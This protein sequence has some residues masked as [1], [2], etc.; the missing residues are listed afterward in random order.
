LSRSFGHTPPPPGHIREGG[1][2]TATPAAYRR[3]LTS[4]SHAKNGLQPHDAK[5]VLWINQGKEKG[6]E[7]PPLFINNWQ[8][9]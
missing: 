9:A 5:G 1:V 8:I 4:R 6:A 2:I 7:Y 3:I